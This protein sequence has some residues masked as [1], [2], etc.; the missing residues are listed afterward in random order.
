MI[1][2][3]S[4]GNMTFGFA[5]RII[6]EEKVLSRIMRGSFDHLWSSAAGSRPQHRLLQTDENT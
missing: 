5:V 4:P 6:V 1:S 2:A 3:E